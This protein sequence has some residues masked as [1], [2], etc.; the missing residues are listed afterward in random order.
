MHVVSED[1]ER[2]GMALGAAEF[3]P[4][5]QR[6]ADRAPLG[7]PR[8]GSRRNRS[9][10]G[11]Q[12]VSP[13]CSC[14]AQPSGWGISWDGGWSVAV[15]SQPPRARRLVFSLATSRGC[16]DTACYHSALKTD[17]VSGAPG[18]KGAARGR[19]RPAVLHPTGALVPHPIEL[20]S[21]TPR[22]GCSPWP[23]PCLKPRRHPKTAGATGSAGTRPRPPQVGSWAAWRTG[24][25]L[26]G[27]TER[28]APEF[29][30]VYAGAGQGGFPAWPA[31]IEWK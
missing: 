24:C 10:A 6:R 26:G 3:H 25:A 22:P 1:G 5:C 8:A 14:P 21:T 23:S 15:A 18:P 31:A 11:T 16:P 19:G 9:A 28:A 30:C 17:L 4:A 20:R 13:R 7:P 27:L 2:P 12:T 29:A